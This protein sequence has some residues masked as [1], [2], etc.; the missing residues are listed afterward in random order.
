[1]Q[2]AVDHQIKRI[3]NFVGRVSVQYGQHRALLQGHIAQYGQLAIHRQGGRPQCDGVRDELAV[4]GFFA[5]REDKITQLAWRIDR[6]R[7]ADRLCSETHIDMGLTFTGQSQVTI[8]IMCNNRAVSATVVSTKA[9]ITDFD[10]IAQI[11]DKQRGI[12]LQLH[13]GLAGYQI[14]DDRVRRDSQAR[15]I[16][17]HIATFRVIRIA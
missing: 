8:N 9:F 17:R 16:G 1:M 14:T 13:A 15:H 12:D 7:H 3:D 6:H 5:F 10:V 2:G 11:V 4:Q